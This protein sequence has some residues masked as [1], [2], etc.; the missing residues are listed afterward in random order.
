MIR[1][2]IIDDEP[3]NIKLVDSIIRDHCPQLTVVGTTDDLW[4]VTSLVNELHPS[5][6]LLDIEFPAGNIFTVLEELPEKDFQIIFITA[7]NTYAAEAFRQNAVDYLLKPV[8]RESLVNAIKKVEA[9]LHNQ[10]PSPDIPALIAALRTGFSPSRKIPLPSSDGILFINEA[11]IVR[12]EASGR[13]SLIFLKDQKKLTITKT[14][15]ELEEILNP[16]LFYRV[17]NS[18]IVNLDMIKKYHRGRG[19]MAELA[20]GSVVDVASARKDELLNMMMN[21]SR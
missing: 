1:T 12:C 10:A 15:K 8:T 21:R 16:M 20:D 18:H 11:E 7:H 2:L 9:K 3:R 13:Y 6:L 4:E 19:G 14:L 5:L 17:H